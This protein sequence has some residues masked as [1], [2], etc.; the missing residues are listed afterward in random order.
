MLVNRRFR[1]L[2]KI[3]MLIFHQLKLRKDKFIH[4]SDY[5][6]E[7]IRDN[8]YPQPILDKNG[9]NGLNGLKEY[10]TLSFTKRKEELL[11][12]LFK[13]PQDS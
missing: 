10:I 3:N 1:T 8:C 4:Y 5:L 7:T 9:L 11:G 2:N 12:Q 13:D 6:V